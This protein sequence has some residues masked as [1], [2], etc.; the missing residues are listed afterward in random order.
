M[1][2]G[3]IAR[4]RTAELVKRSDDPVPTVIAKY[5]NG[6]W[7]SGQDDQSWGDRLAWEFGAGYLMPGRTTSVRAR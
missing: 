1:V 3:K 7:D 6:V 2:L 4:N 5:M